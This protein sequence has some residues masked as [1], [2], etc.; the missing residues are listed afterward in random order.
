MKLPEELQYIQNSLLPQRS[1]DVRLDGKV[2]VITGTTSGVGYEAA[3]CLAKAGAH[4][5]MICRNEDK[6][7]KIQ[8]ELA[9]EFGVDVDLILGDFSSLIEVRRAALEVRKKFP[10]IHV[11]I[12]NIGVFNKRRRLTADGYEMTFGVIHLASFL[13]TRLLIENLKIGAPSRVIFVSS[14]AHRFGGFNVKDLNWQR[15]PYIGLFAYGAAKIAQLHTARVLAEQLKDDDV[16]VNVMHPGAVRTNIGM[17]NGF[18]Y[19]LYSRYILRWFLKEPASSGE[20]IYFLVSDPDLKSVT[21][22]YFN[23]T[24][25]EKPAWYAVRPEITDKVW[26]SSE[27]LIQPY[28]DDEQ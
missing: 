18:F 5:V 3:K 24:I 4:L 28:L 19:R 23:Q 8:Q 26:A 27:E 25:E 1:T 12:N 16:S 22:R 17:N 7:K 2:C 10:E 21:G 14:E 13:F 15:R 20:A 9:G 6:G 11:L